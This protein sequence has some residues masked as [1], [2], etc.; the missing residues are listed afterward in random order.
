[1]PVNRY[2]VNALERHLFFGRIMKEQGRGHGDDLCKSNDSCRH[3][4][5]F[6]AWFFYCPRP[7]NTRGREK[8]PLPL[9]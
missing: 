2:V 4:C 3:V 6:A 5:D 1:M 7:F 8:R 9:G